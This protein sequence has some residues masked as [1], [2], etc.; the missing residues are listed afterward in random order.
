MSLGWGHPLYPWGEFT[1]GA[2]KWKTD[3]TDEWNR[4]SCVHGC[5]LMF[6]Y[7]ENLTCVISRTYS[8]CLIWSGYVLFLFS[9]FLLLYLSISLFLFIPIHILHSI[10]QSNFLF[11][12]QNNHFLK[13]LFSTV[14]NF[15]KGFSWNQCRILIHILTLIIW[16]H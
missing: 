7:V 1:N 13:L 10:N 11:S 9:F 16:T 14:C 6:T 15:T 8:T 4:I 5:L 12:L 3:R 2:H